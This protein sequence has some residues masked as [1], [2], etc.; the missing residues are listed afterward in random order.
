MDNDHEP[1]NDDDNEETVE[2]SPPIL[3][4]ADAADT[5]VE[6]QIKIE[7]NNV[8]NPS[9]QHPRVVR[10][11]P[12]AT[13]GGTSWK[14]MGKHV[15]SRLRRLIAPHVYRSFA[16]MYQDAVAAEEDTTT[17]F[18][19]L[20][21]EIPLW[22]EVCP[23]VLDSETSGVL[24]AVPKLTDYLRLIFTAHV[25]TVVA[26]RFKDNPESID[27]EIPL[28]SEF[29]HVLYCICADAFYTDSESLMIPTDGNLASIRVATK[30]RQKLG[31]QLI[32]A[33]ID[34]AIGSMVPTDQAI[35]DHL[36]FLLEDEDADADAYDVKKEPGSDPAD[37]NNESFK[38][39]ASDLPQPVPAT[40]MDPPS[41]S[42]EEPSTKKVTIEKQRWNNGGGGAQAHAESIDALMSGLD[43]KA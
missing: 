26:L 6:R 28:E 2:A 30:K 19:M 5:A 40:S 12:I 29:V 9:K 7:P 39:T 14:D 32:S 37:D 10:Q 22:P 35:Q 27:V 23:D 42:G 38:V 16:T 21:E 41:D 15:L 13:Y 31:L 18:L 4:V 34:E 36:L 17:F 24:D 3:P 8:P 25:M 43:D 20:M 1:G 11:K 33:A